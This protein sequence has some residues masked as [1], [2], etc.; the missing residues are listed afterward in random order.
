M[1]PHDVLDRPVFR[2]YLE[3]EPEWYREQVLFQER[4][5]Q[6]RELLERQEVEALRETWVDDALHG[7]LVEIESRQCPRPLARA[8]LLGRPNAARRRRASNRGSPARPSDPD[9]SGVEPAS[10]GCSAYSDVGDD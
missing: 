1:V 7:L 10:A 5:E 2:P 9:H 3:D 6:L 8:R 4:D